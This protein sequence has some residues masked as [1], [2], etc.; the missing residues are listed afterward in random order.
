VT[1]QNGHGTHCAGT[2]GGSRFG[3]AKS[4]RLIAVKVLGASGSGATSGVIK[5]IEYVTEQHQNGNARTVAS[6][7]LGGT[8]DGGKNAAIRAS[9]QAGCVYSVAAGN[10]NGNACNHYPAS[11]PDVICVGSTTITNVG[12]YDTDDRSS[13]SNYGSCV[14]IWAPGSSIT[15][16]GI[17]SPPSSSVKSGTSMACPHVTGVAAVLLSQYPDLTPVQVRSTLVGMAQ[18][19]LI[20]NVMAGSPNKLL[21]LDCD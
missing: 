6:M 4:S 13:F 7:S 21:Y 17:T 12:G 11:S 5:G 19:G 3:I 9:V 18:D 2:A 8:S 1:D 14:S 15:S 20:R 10:S 16:A